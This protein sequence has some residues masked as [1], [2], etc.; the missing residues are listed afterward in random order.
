MFKI[1]FFTP[2]I[3]VRGSCTALYDYAVSIKEYYN[4]DGIII[5]YPLEKQNYD[6]IALKK[7]S[8]RFPIFFCEDTQQIDEILTKENC[9]MLYCIKY[10]KNDGI[11]SNRFLTAIHCVFDM[12][13][14]HGDIYAGVS[15]YVAKKYNK[16]LFV[17]HM[18]SLQPSKTKENMRKILGI[19][20]EALVFGRHGGYDT[21]NLGFAQ[22][23]ISH[24][25]RERDDIYFVFVNTPQFDNHEHIFFLDKIIDNDS[26][27]KFINTCDAHLECGTLGHSYG[28]SCSEVSINNLPMI[29]YDSP[30]LW[31]R[32]H[33]DIL[34]D[35]AKYFHNDGELHHILT[36]F[37]KE[38]H[39]TRNWNAYREYTPKKVIKKFYDV[40]IKDTYEAKHKTNS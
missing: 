34:N 38:H 4:I 11:I 2:A 27:N 24:V 31:N 6:D 36:T 8:Q 14:P 9:D 23:V 28:L 22:E 20:E 25:V 21:F 40:F 5:T 10:G 35:K 32:S 39:R 13:E 1:C 33:I 37:N 12:S 15:E 29:L 26:K 16:E 19:P 17:P 3:D 18:T 7:F 30:T